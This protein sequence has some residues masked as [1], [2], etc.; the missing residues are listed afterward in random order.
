M[1][2][3][4]SFILEISWSWTA[5]SDKFLAGAVPVLEASSGGSSNDSGAL[6]IVSSSLLLDKVS[7]PVCESSDLDKYAEE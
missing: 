3:L 7:D 4:Y 5:S 1:P 6:E 2:N